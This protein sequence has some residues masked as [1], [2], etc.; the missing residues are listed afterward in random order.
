MIGRKDIGCIRPSLCLKRT[1]WR[2]KN[3]KS[4]RG[5][6][7]ERKGRIDPWGRGELLRLGTPTL[8]EGKKKRISTGVKAKI[9]T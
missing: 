3:E 7:R 8:E 6:L 2:N 4:R 5:N 9:P 1:E